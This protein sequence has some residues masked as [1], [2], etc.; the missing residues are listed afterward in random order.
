[1]TISVIVPVYNAEKYLK[2]CLLSLHEQSCDIDLEFIIVN[3]GSDDGSEQICEKIIKID[4][5]FKYYYKNNGGSASARNFGIEHAIGEYISFVDSDDYVEK[6]YFY[7]MYQMA[8]NN[9]AEIVVCPYTY[10][11]AGSSNVVFPIMSEGIYN[12]TQKK[13]IMEG[14]IALDIRG[15][16][17]V[18]SALWAKL[19]KKQLVCKEYKKVNEQIRIGEDLALVVRCLNSANSVFVSGCKNSGYHYITRPGQITRSYD[20]I[21]EQRVPLLFNSLISANNEKSI[22]SFEEQFEKIV[23]SNICAGFENLIY[24]DK[25]PYRTIKTR[26]KY[27]CTMA[28]YYSEIKI[29]K[30]DNKEER[31]KKNL[32]KIGNSFFIYIVYLFLAR[33]FGYRGESK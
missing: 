33:Q 10:E 7:N 17:T 30:K 28:N 23:I 22:A 32:I 15:N 25:M 19:F 2:K 21:Y 5:R 12:K 13:L 20:A 8:K 14:A 31:V 29:L 4:N 26:I 3:D 9:N 11:F 1:M 24:Y 18:T 16:R 6:D 27:L